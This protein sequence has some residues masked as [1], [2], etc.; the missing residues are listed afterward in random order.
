MIINK[1]PLILAISGGILFLLGILF[2]RLPPPKTVEIIEDYHLATKSAQLIHV[3][4]AGA[5]LKP[6]V[7]A[8]PP[9]SR[10]QELLVSAGGITA[11]ADEDYIAQSLNRAAKLSDGSKIYI[12]KK[13]ENLNRQTSGKV[14]GAETRLLNINRANLSELDSLPGVGMTTA[15][16]IISGRPY[17]RIEDLS[18]KKII[19]QSVWVK[20][21]DK[22]TVN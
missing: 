20:I 11:L 16:K 4:I 6:G 3:D 21:K 7:Y 22:I 2:L 8:L 13:G 5:V 19:N 12:P 17:Q 10:L 1:L 15:E 9:G 18:E 14:A